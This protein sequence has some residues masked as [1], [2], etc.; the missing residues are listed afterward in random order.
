MRTGR[1]QHQQQQQHQ[2]QSPPAAIGPDAAAA[3]VAETP[4]LQN[5]QA[6]Q[7]CDDEA[8]GDA[9]GHV[10]S[11]DVGA[12]CDKASHKILLEFRRPGNALGAHTRELNAG[13]EQQHAK[14]HLREV[15]DHYIYALPEDQRKDDFGNAKHQDRTT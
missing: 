10:L 2:E 13:E 15:N 11:T 3:S 4:Q 14:H 8:G 12:S 9:Q 1:Q 7:E 6:L 5:L